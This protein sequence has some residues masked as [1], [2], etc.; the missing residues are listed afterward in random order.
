[1]AVAG[2]RT[3]PRPHPVLAHCYFPF[4]PSSPELGRVAPPCQPASI[5]SGTG[6]AGPTGRALTMAGLRAGWGE[7]EDR[8]KARGP[9]R[10]TA[11]RAT[12]LPLQWLG[13]QQG[14]RGTEIRRIMV[15]CRYGSGRSNGHGRQLASL[16]N[17]ATANW[18]DAL[19]ESPQTM[20]GSFSLVEAMSLA[21]SC[22]G[23]ENRSAL[24]YDSYPSSCP[25]WGEWQG[26][27]KGSGGS[28][29]QGGSF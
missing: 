26:K 16:L 5:E 9:R 11:A 12:D 6:A 7:Q 8:G 23:G 14:W 1:L 3:A 22:S 20:V 4:L 24:S 25:G 27:R 17:A 29:V 15:R 10:C 28:G 19:P 18:Q 13:A 2:V 21:R